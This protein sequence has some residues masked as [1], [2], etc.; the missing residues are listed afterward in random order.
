MV[1][2]RIFW[3][4][5]VFAAFECVRDY[6]QELTDYYS[7][8]ESQCV[9]KA[10]SGILGVCRNEGVEYLSVEERKYLALKLTLCEMNN[11]HIQMPPGCLEMTTEQDHDVCIAI[12]EKIPQY[13]TSFSGNFRE[14]KKICFEESLP[15]E[16]GQILNL[17]TNITNTF[18]KLDREFNDSLKDSEDQQVKLKKKLEELMDQIESITET[19]MTNQY[20]TMKGLKDTTIDLQNSFKN[21]LELVT[22]LTAIGQNDLNEMAV[23]LNFLNKELGE[24][25]KAIVDS[26]IE[27]VI[28]ELRDSVKE[29]A[30]EISDSVSQA[31]DDV[32]EKVNEMGSF[33][34]ETEQ[35]EALIFRNLMDTDKLVSKINDVLGNTQ[36]K[37]MVQQQNIQ[38]NEAYINEFLMN[39]FD[40]LEECF[41][42]VEERMHDSL[43]EID[44]KV[45]RTL[46]TISQTNEKIEYFMNLLL[47]ISFIPTFMNTKMKDLHTI[48]IQTTKFLIKQLKT[49]TVS[50]EILIRLLV[51]LPTIPFVYQ[52][53]SLVTSIMK[54]SAPSPKSV[55][56]K[57]SRS[58]I[59][60]ITVCV[61]YLS[62]LIV[63][64][65]ML[66]SS[67]PTV[68]WR[69]AKSSY[70]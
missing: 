69:D 45:A 14:I 32:K 65:V 5:S 50:T 44:T 29:Q 49:I 43:N 10:L 7:A 22:S 3:V 61:I 46:K 51:L 20:D 19:L 24:I 60:F 13:W 42:E 58:P 56:R 16:K 41:L 28:T 38:H 11:L 1:L 12:L 27:T 64:V 48:T 35:K 47:P 34:K 30:N 9:K 54:S 59:I 52:I 33:L 70:Q 26:G 8:K 66:N 6:T 18:I 25:R 62:F 37:A 21:S 57:K 67:K 36:H 31:V 55:L 23:N 15:Y 68:M 63:F 40:G 4:F 17:Y 2:I 39:L 53:F